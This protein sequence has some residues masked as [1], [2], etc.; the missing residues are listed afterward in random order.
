M[1]HAGEWRVLH[2]HTFRSLTLKMSS[3]R[4]A[5]LKCCS[6]MNPAPVTDYSYK[7]KTSQTPDASAHKHWSFLIVLLIRR[8]NFMSSKLC[9]SALLFITCCSKILFY[10]RSFFFLSLELICFWCEQRTEVSFLCQWQK[11]LKEWRGQ[12]RRAES[13]HLHFKREGAWGGGKHSQP[14]KALS[15]ICSSHL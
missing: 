1:T 3:S 15:K 9:S 8:P 11:W 10:G 5:A 6:A 4:W 12:R 13:A 14:D 7:T 2:L